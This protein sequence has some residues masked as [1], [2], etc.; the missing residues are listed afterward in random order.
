[1]ILA[2]SGEISPDLGRFSPDQ[3]LLQPNRSH[4]IFDLL[5]VY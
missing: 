2:G 3:V 4:L 5:I 1:M